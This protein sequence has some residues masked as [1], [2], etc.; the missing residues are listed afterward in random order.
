MI[1]VD[2]KPPHIPLEAVRILRGTL[3]ADEPSTGGG[4]AD[5]DWELIPY[6]RIVNKLPVLV[7]S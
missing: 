6:V 2:R 5:K 7:S 4:S 1:D 3:P